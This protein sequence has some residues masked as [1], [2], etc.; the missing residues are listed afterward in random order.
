VQATVASVDNPGLN[1]QA[2]ARV[3]AYIEAHLGDA[4]TLDDL[5]AAACISRFHFARLFRATTQ[6][7]PMQ[8]VRQQRVAR[9]QALL[10][11]SS[12]PISAVAADLGFFDHSHFT[13]TF[14]RLTGIPPGRF[15]RE[16]AH[17]RTV[18]ACA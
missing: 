2:L 3:C 8:F 14:R 17:A 4:I 10:A 6:C 15:T 12:R 7:S 13:R 5:A 11:Q 16:C 1:P 9:A 18:G